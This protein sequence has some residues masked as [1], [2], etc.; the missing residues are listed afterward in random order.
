MQK[1][2]LITGGAG[3]VGSRLLL[4]LLEQNHKVK[5]YDTLYFG[6]EH[7]P[8][9]KNFEVIKGDIRDIKKFEDAVTEI[10]VVIHL[11]CISNDA[12]FSLDE[13]L[14]KTINFDAFEPIVIAAKKKGVKRFI[15][16]STSSVYG[17]SDK[18]DV[19]EEYA[20]FLYTLSIDDLLYLKGSYESD[21]V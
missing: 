12:S 5:I 16:A 14:S 4:D 19:T 2:I 1:K 18:K 17:L 10:D 7:L 11:A 15:Y 8:K 20:D 9:H 21:I 3:Y 13:K 6:S